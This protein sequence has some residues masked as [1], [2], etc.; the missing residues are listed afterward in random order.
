MVA[1][2]P[3]NTSS[4]ED[5][6]DANE[7]FPYTTADRC[8]CKRRPQHNTTHTGFRQ[9]RLSNSMIQ[10]QRRQS[11]GLGVETPR[12]WDRMSWVV[13]AGVGL[14]E[15]LFISMCRNSSFFLGYS[16]NLTF[17]IRATFFYRN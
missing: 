16:R 13:E 8:I 6:M 4:M 9:G 1:A 3:I 7:G 12:F 5:V 14:H 17:F 15:I 11:W 10:H 2:V